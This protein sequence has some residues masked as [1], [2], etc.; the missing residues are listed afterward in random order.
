MDYDIAHFYS[1]T[2]LVYLEMRRR[3][4]KVDAN[5]FKKWVGDSWFWWS[6]HYV[7]DKAHIFEGWHNDRY[8]TQ[9]YFNLQEKY[10]CGGISEKE[11]SKI[12]G[13]K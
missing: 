10:D 11:W 5:C 9:C 2:K 7:V 3:G 4:Y 13:S 1:Y 8:L 12:G 6:G